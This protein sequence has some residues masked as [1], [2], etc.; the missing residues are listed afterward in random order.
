MTQKVYLELLRIEY[1]SWPSDAVLEEDRDSTHGRSD[2]NPIRTW[3]EE[4]HL[5]H[6]FNYT[7]SPDLSLIKN[8]WQA[9]KANLRKFTYH[10]EESLYE[11]AKEGWKGL[12]QKTINAWVD[13]MPIRLQAVIDAKG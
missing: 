6:Y 8:A 2:S 7:H 11:V 3:K 12:S 5:L 1:T 9:P 13:S 10:D 4:H